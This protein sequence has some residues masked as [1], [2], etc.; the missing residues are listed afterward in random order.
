MKHRVKSE[1]ERIESN[2]GVYIHFNENFTLN[3]YQADKLIE[4]LKNEI[5]KALPCKFNFLGFKVH[6]YRNLDE[7]VKGA[8]PFSFLQP[9]SKVMPEPIR[10][11]IREIFYTKKSQFQACSPVFWVIDCQ[12]WEY[13]IT[14]YKTAFYGNSIR[15]EKTIL[16]LLTDPSLDGLSTK[17]DETGLFYEADAKHLSGILVLYCGN[18]Y[19]LFNPYTKY[20]LDSES[21]RQLLNALQLN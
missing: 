1:I 14:D 2:L 21:I 12:K 9:K 16:E 5:E 11:Q 15:A 17:P 10:R 18:V 20:P 13:D 6:I 19:L 3:K 4:K 7:N 8:T